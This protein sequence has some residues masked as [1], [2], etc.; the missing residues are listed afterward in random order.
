MLDNIFTSVLTE[1]ISA[2]SF[3]ICTLTSV[4]L[5]AVIALTYSYRNRT[6]KGFVVTLALLPAI[7]EVVILLVNG[8]LGAGVAVAGAFS[9]IRFRSAPGTAKE[10]TGV[11]LTMAVGLATG[12][13]Y[14]GIAVILTLL[15]CA[16]E[17]IYSLTGFGEVRGNP[18]MLKVTVPENIDYNEVFDG[19]FEKYTK[20]HE[21]I[22]VKTSGL[23]SLFIL[24]Y[25]ITLR[26]IKKEKEFIDEVRCR[27]GNLDIIIS[28]PENVRE[29][30]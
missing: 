10:I 22:K 30:L 23:G 3:F 7:V 29:E 19:I 24:T 16:L 6:T 28:R 27:N 2:E 20:Q 25:E 8:N 14:I 17:I 18:K 21:L 13:G 1:G 15:L 4:I 26:D 11:F 12:M 5:G 9:L